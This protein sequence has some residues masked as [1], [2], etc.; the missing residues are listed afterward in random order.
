MNNPAN[1]YASVF[2]SDGYNLASAHLK[3]DLSA[4]SVFS[5]LRTQY[6]QIDILI[7]SFIKR[8]NHS[9]VNVDCKKG[10]EFCCHQPVFANVHEMLLV[11][12]YI[13][14]HFE[15]G[16]LQSVRE[17]ARIKCEK[18]DVT[19]LHEL[20]K[21]SHPCPLLKN[22]SCSVYP[23]RPMACRIYLSSDVNSCIRRFEHTEDGT[24]FPALFEFVLM[25]GRNMNEGFAA[26][27]RKQGLQISENRFEILLNQIL[28]NDRI[29]E[30]WLKK[31]LV[32]ESFDWGDSN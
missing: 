3:N 23:V 31:Q 25:A 6:E 16:E 14:H 21:H 27:L 26:F 32:I 30:E 18:T 24:H 28:S 5:A 12:H 11:V 13:K 29:Q 2:F 22:G 7:D 10:C 19:T 17:K 1:D 4:H 9:G 15:V 20:M 8:C